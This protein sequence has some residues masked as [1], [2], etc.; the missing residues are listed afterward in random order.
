MSQYIGKVMWFN[1]AKGFGFLSH[2]GA[3]DVF[4]HFSAIA[5]D[6]YKTLAEGDEVSFDI[7]QG[8]KGMQADDVRLLRSEGHPKVT[9][10]ETQE[11]V[12]QVGAA[13]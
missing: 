2:D 1:N 13:A 6:G 9:T 7:I 10:P 12:T 8:D 11:M 3:P 5:R 4:V